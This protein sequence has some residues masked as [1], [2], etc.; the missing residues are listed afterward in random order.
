MRLWQK[1]Q[2]RSNDSSTFLQQKQN[3]QAGFSKHCSWQQTR[4]V[5]Y[6][7]L[8]IVSFSRDCRS[9]ALDKPLTT[10]SVRFCSPKL[11]NED[12]TNGKTT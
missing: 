6:L 12:L 4:Q 1:A 7:F 2:A 5:Y 9:C 8:Q 10:A 3:H 11:L